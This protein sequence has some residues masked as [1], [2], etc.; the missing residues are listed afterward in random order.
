MKNLILYILL[1]GLLYLGSCRQ[2]DESASAD[3]GLSNTPVDSFLLIPL[4]KGVEQVAMTPQIKNTVWFLVQNDSLIGMDVQP[5]HQLR[6]L[7][8]PPA[9]RGTWIRISDFASDPFNGDWYLG[10]KGL[11]RYNAVNQTFEPLISGRRGKLGIFKDYLFYG[12]THDEIFLLHK[13]TGAV[14]TVR[15]HLGD[16]W[17]FSTQQTSFGVLVNHYRYVPEEKRFRTLESIGIHTLPA[18]GFHNLIEQDSFISFSEGRSQNTVFWLYGQ[19]RFIETYYADLDGR[20]YE[21]GR[22]WTLH[23][24]INRWIISEN[25]SKKFEFSLPPQWGLR[26]LNDDHKYWILSG[27]IFSF[28][29]KTEQF[30]QHPQF[31]NGRAPKQYF[32]DQLHL[33]LLYDDVI[34]ILNKS[35]LEVHKTAFNASDWLAEKNEY[36]EWFEAGRADMWQNL[37]VD[38][39]FRFVSETEVRFPEYIAWYGDISHQYACDYFQDNRFRTEFLRALLTHQLDSSTL[40]ANM[41]CLADALASKGEFR[42]LAR[43]G[44]YRELYSDHCAQEYFNKYRY[45]STFDSLKLYFEELRRLDRKISDPDSLILLKILA[46]EPVCRSALF[47]HEGC[48]GCN[49]SPMDRQLSSFLKKHPD[50]HLVP[51]A[52]YHRV[53]LKNYTNHD[54]VADF[55]FD[56][57]YFMLQYPDSPRILDVVQTLLPTYVYDQDFELTNKRQKAKNLLEFARQRFPEY[58]QTKAFRILERDFKAM[59]KR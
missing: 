8:L 55:V 5:P 22:F 13:A 33:Y 50:S 29:R 34:A 39:F 24:G 44:A 37:S 19:R 51:E 56:Y 35:F 2:S 48:G 59:Q 21:D 30:Y 11:Y 45:E 16:D 10:A 43:L 58:A 31:I 49:F 12:T 52:A 7:H 41:Y 46:M 1:P 6:V 47:C 4:P 54:R 18:S 57:E 20:I 27:S 40:C 3:L 25:T 42:S 9:L 32:Q 14:D 17:D 15:Q 53:R 36:K 23:N 28:D 26:F 38:R